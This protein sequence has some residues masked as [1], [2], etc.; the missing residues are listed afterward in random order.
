MMFKARALFT[1]LILLASS[2]AHAFVELEARKP[3]D[4]E[5]SKLSP[6]WA[7]E[8]VG[9]DLAKEELRQIPGLTPVPFAVYDGGFEKAYV[10]LIHDI[11]VDQ[12]QDRGRR[13]RANH[14]TKVVNIINGP[15]MI[16]VSE[17]VDYVQLRRTS[18]GAFYFGAIED[19]SKLPVAPQI[20]SNSMG[21]PGERITE[22]TKMLDEHGLIWVLAAGN[23]HPTPIAD[24]E[25]TPHV[26]SV[27]SYSPRGL[28]T[29]YS[30]ESKELD[31]LAPADG[32]QASINGSGEADTFGATSG[33]TPMVSGT[34]ANMKALLPSLNRAEAE[35]ILKRT[36][37]RSFNSLYS[38]VNHAKLL[39]S[40]KAVRVAMNLRA[41]CGQN[42]TCLS[43]EI[44]N[45][46][47][48]QFSALPLSSEA[49]NICTNSKSVL[50]KE[51]MVAL[52]KN[53]LLN[54]AH[55]KF[56]QLLS[57]A[58]RNEGYSINA[59]YFENL[60]LIYK[61]PRVLQNK[62]RQQAAEAVLKDYS[63]SASLRDLELL[64]D[65]FK[66]ALTKAIKADIGIGRFNAQNYLE[67]FAKAP[68]AVVVTE[69][70][71]P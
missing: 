19:I 59:D 24:Y 41:V 5:G 42:V 57:C 15:G 26:I 4:V 58:H 40:Y 52:R 56:N 18:P 23:D 44:N 63:E 53:A 67:R 31:I 60:V 11:P 64:D 13:M 6:Y 37:I 65:S 1:S 7:Q 12:E 28:Q 70:A 38:K 48:Y 49:E 8:Y 32:Y 66:E 36:A 69:A 17:L 29:I 45:P 27:G 47:N 14:G 16:S 20:I 61:A 46:K 68:R 51:D 50:N 25:V 54:P 33:A 39:N 55:V 43:K 71:R 10:N 22:L 62:I 2:L 30:Q 34:I 3:L 9:A 35:T 21:W